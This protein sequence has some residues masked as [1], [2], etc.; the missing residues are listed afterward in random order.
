MSDTGRQS[1][2]D[3]LGAAVKVFLFAWLFYNISVSHLESSPIPRRLPRSTLATSSRETS[4]P[5]CPLPNQ[6]FVQSSL[7]VIHS[8]DST[9]SEK[10]GSQKLGDVFSSNSNENGVGHLPCTCNS[11]FTLDY[12]NPLW[13]KQKISLEWVKRNKLFRQ[14]TDWNMNTVLLPCNHTTYQTICHSVLYCML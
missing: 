12:S 10:S 5:W 14:L 13:K 1:F 2:T 11:T 9:Q 4:I 7:F 8:A 3:K 6:R